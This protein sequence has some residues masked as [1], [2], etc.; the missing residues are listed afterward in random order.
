MYPLKPFWRSDAGAASIDWVVMLVC[1]A[2]LALFVLHHVF[3]GLGPTI[4]VI[5]RTDILTPERQD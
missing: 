4:E 5:E 1:V 3:S 2:V